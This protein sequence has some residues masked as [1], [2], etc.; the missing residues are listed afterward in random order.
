MIPAITVVGLLMANP[1]PAP[2]EVPQAATVVLEQNRGP[3]SEQRKIIVHSVE[4][5]GSEEVVIGVPYTATAEIESTQ[6]LPDGNRIVNHRSERLA[7]DSAGRSR[8]ELR[9]SGL[10][11]L[12]VAGPSVVLIYDP[13]SQSEYTLDPTRHTARVTKVETINVR[14]RTEPSQPAANAGRRQIVRENLGT[15]T[16]E[17]F[18]A[19]G[20]RVT[21]KI[22]A[23][24]LGNE[25]PHSISVEIWYAPELRTVIERKRSDPRSGDTVYRL[26]GIRRAEPDP[27]LFKIPPDF[28]LITGTDSVP[29]R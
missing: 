17:G 18:V 6:L 7:R 22:A 13:V 1:I 8:R 27:S 14:A 15:Q 19:E 26:T 5:V 20:T 10:A 23:G 2:Q 16:I 9:I 25:Q 4:G 12:E 29:A 11:G 21:S 3:S 24:L 28:K